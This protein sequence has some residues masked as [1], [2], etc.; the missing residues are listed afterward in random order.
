M[1]RPEVSMILK[2]FFFVIVIANVY[3][4]KR[5]LQFKYFA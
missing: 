5:S 3:Q 2:Q 1:E 4:V